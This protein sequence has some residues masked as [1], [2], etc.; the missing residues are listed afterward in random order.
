MSSKNL[1]ALLIGF[2]MVLW[3]LSG[4]M[5]ADK[6]LGADLAD[7]NA[8]PYLVRAQHSVATSKI[9]SLNLSGQTE[10]SR[11]VTVRAE[12]PGRIERLMVSQ[13]QA[14]ERGDVL[15]QLAVN[16]RDSDFAEAKAAYKSAKLEYQGLLDLKGRG[17]QSDINVARAEATLASTEARMKQAEL[18]LANT[19]IKAPF[20][21]VVE[22]QPVEQGDY[23]NIG[24]PCV[25]IME[26]DPIL[27]R[28]QV[29][30][31]SINQ[32]SLGEM[33]DVELITGERL[34]GKVTF[35]ARSPDSTTRTYEIEATVSEPG[36]N[37]RAGLSARVSVP[38]TSQLAH[39]I[40]PAALVLND[41]GEMGVR[42]VDD[43]NR[44]EFKTVK[45]VSESNEGIWV[46]GLPL[47][48]NLIIVGQEEVFSGQVVEVD[49]S[50]I[51]RP[52]TT[53][54]GATPGS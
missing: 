22:E 6:P 13:G 9:T 2:G 26:V 54:A 50:P 33:V 49:Y 47:E 12:V 36:P 41:E 23:L 11:I 45:V 14:V 28:A 52:T 25:T 51:G 44:V 17:L 15:C 3:L 32:V 53:I 20:A 30:E 29:A 38:L 7:E 19:Q 8:A 46:D 48:V 1:V 42:L 4:T 40:T 35:I 34:K 16:T 39:L 24:Q 27:V 43:N 21:G 31:R 10:A 18:A 37:I 5:S